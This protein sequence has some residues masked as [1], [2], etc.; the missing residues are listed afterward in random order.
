MVSKNTNFQTDD[1]DTILIFLTHHIIHKNLQHKCFNLLIFCS[2]ND[3][4]LKTDETHVQC[5]QNS[6]EKNQTAFRKQKG[7]DRL[8]QSYHIQTCLYL[9]FLYV[10]TNF[11]I[12]SQNNYANIFYFNRMVIELSD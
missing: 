1:Q 5:R 9:L 2:L 12:L 4:H 7:C 3:Y 6:Q 11:L 8:R 10:K